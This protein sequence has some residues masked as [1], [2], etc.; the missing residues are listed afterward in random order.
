MWG[1]VLYYIFSFPV[2]KAG[3]QSWP[4]DGISGPITQLTLVIV[5]PGE[6]LTR[7]RARH[8]VQ[9]TRRYRYDLATLG[10]QQGCQ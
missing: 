9:R 7:V 1:C 5:A 8:T 6:H 3:H 10:T 4:L 2:L